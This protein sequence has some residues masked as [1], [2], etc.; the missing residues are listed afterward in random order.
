MLSPEKLTSQDIVAFDRAYI[1]YEKFEKLT[2]NKVIYVTKMKRNL[3]YE[4]ESDTFYQNQ[5]GETICREQIVIFRKELA[6]KTINH[7]ARI[8]IYTD[9]EGKNHKKP[10]LISLLTNDFNINYDDIITIYKKRWLI[11]S[12]FKQL[13]QNFPLK[14]F[15]GESENAIKIQVWV[16]LIA[17]LLLTIMKKKI[18]RHWSFS[19][20]ATTIRILL[21]QY[22]NFESFFESP[23][24]DLKRMLEEAQKSPPIS[25]YQL[26][27]F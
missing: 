10:K 12:L 15:Y 1:N 8:V 25:S 7:R 13:K 14:Y 4:L 3:K 6:E 26:S 24:K 9:I 2:E 20:I 16:V 27:L 21:M 22:I 23:E 19:G 5:N 18:K 17:N 11:E